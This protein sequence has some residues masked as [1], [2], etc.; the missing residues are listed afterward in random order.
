MAGN[1]MSAE[2]AAYKTDNI[3]YNAKKRQTL[4]IHRTE[5]AIEVL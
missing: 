3:E 4:E 2:P 5:E 1:R